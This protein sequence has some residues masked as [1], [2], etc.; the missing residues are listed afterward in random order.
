MGE[1]VRILDL[2]KQMIRLAGLTPDKDVEI[3]II[4]ARPGEKLFEE[5][6][7][8]AEPLVATDCPGILLAAPRTADINAVNEAIERLR[9]H[10]EQF[11]EDGVFRVI[12]EMVP[13]F[14]GHKEDQ[15]S[16]ASG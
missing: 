16:A 6:F 11:D 10:C 2:A 9:G 13:E 1:P 12:H 8:G 7:H 14:T 4:G 5:V 15:R 3:K